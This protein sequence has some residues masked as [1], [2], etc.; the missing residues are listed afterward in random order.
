MTSSADSLNRLG[1]ELQLRGDEEGA[2][3]HY[4]AALHL[5]PHF[6]PAMVNLATILSNRN[7]LSAAAAIMAQVAALVP[8]EPKALSNLGNLLTRLERYD[9]AEPVLRRAAE[10]SPDDTAVWHNLLLLAHRMGDHDLALDY[11]DR[12]LALGADTPAVRNDRAHLLLAAGRLREALVDYE[13]RWHTLAHLE[14]W[15]FHIPEWKGEDLSDKHILV[16]HEQGFGDTIMTARFLR[17]LAER[18]KRVTFGLPPALL[19]LFDQQQW[20]IDTI[21][22]PDMTEEQARHFD[23]QS[24]LWSAVRWLGIEQRDINGK[25]YLRA[26]DLVVPPVLSKPALNVGICWASGKR[27]TQMDWRRRVSPLRLWL[28]LAEVPGVHLWSL[29]YEAEARAEIEELGAEAIVNDRT[30]AL[31]S[32]ADTAAFVSQLDLVISVDTAAAHLAAAMG[33]ETWMLSQYTPCW[34]WWSIADGS[35]APWY[36]SMRILRQP[37]PSDWDAQ[38]STC[39]D[40][41]RNRPLYPS[42]LGIRG[43]RSSERAERVSDRERSERRAEPLG[44]LEEAIA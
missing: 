41:L 43:A 27:G 39:A 33:V 19:A 21:S 3:V 17:L 5:D 10:I 9:E 1:T 18:A 13:A 28:R 26:P 40:W 36:D 16:H 15:D 25:P 30:R 22:I 38:L 42:P 14:S 32:F 6:V 34:R 8:G 24:P 11:M 31:S 29:S 35:G 20:P 37:N 44:S 7:Q 12:L 23:L 4:L 2:R